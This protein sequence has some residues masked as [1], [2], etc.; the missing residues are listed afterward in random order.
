MVT[1]ITSASFVAAADGTACGDISV[2]SFKRIL[3]KAWQGDAVC[4]FPRLPIR[5]FCKGWVAL[6]FYEHRAQ[7]LGYEASM[8]T[9]QKHPVKGINVMCFELNELCAWSRS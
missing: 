9:T 5:T 1:T 8:Y 2:S 3:S 7:I 6:K 4:C